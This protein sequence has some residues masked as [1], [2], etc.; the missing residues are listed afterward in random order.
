MLEVIDLEA[1]RALTFGASLT[2]DENQGVPLEFVSDELI[3][4]SRWSVLHMIVIR[5]LGDLYGFNY[6]EPATEY[7]ESGPED[8]YE[9]DSDGMVKVFKVIEVPTVTYM[10]VS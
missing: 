10:R 7:Q 3:Y 1:A 4:T 5:H 2:A 6:D 9:L 8:Y